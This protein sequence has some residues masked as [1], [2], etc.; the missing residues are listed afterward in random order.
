MWFCITG[1]LC[2]DS[3][4]IPPAFRSRFTL[5]RNAKLTVSK[6]VISIFRPRFAEFKNR[7]IRSF[8][9]TDHRPLTTVH[10]PSVVQACPKV[11][12]TGKLLITSSLRVCPSQIREKTENCA[13]LCHKIRVTPLFAWV[14]SLLQMLYLAKRLGQ[15]CK[16]S[17][18]DQRK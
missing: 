10:C 6:R 8:L 13:T 5:N 9:T 7:L 12:G 15:T 2:S 3:A 18:A 17:A 4:A 1:I 14:K 16:E 11:F